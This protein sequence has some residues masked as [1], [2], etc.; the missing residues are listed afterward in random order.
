[1]LQKQTQPERQKS[2]GSGSQF[3]VP[4]ILVLIFKFLSECKDVSARVKII[5]DLLDLLDS[6]PSNIEA[7]MVLIHVILLYPFWPRYL[8]SSNIVSCL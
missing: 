2:K 8:I 1:M 3:F 5:A 7:L 6:S 4:Q